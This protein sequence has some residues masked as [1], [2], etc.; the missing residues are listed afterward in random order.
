MH[1]LWICLLYAYIIDMLII[2]I[3]YGYAYYMHNIILSTSQI[4]QLIVS[5]FVH[6]TQSIVRLNR[7]H[8]MP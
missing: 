8:D 7:W 1:I 6:D 5:C 3:Y 4:L 2:C